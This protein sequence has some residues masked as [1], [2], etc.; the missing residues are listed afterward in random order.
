MT[1]RQPIDRMDAIDQ[2]L[3]E[4]EIEIDRGELI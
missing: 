3:D 4:L 1:E 2:R